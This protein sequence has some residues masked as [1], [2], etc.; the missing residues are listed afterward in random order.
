MSRM[1]LHASYI[2]TGKQEGRQEWQGR[3][4]VAHGLTQQPVSFHH[5]TLAALLLV[6]NSLPFCVFFP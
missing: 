6:W 1:K 4:P 3:A 2:G 5:Q